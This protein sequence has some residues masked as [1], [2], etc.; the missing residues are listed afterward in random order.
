MD[1]YIFRLKLFKLDW[2]KFSFAYGLQTKAKKENESR[3]FE[4]QFELQ[5]VHLCSGANLI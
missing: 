4:T 3:K 5:Q 2:F 1:N